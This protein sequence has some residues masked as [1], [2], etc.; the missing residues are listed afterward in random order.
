MML[1]HSNAE[2]AG[3]RRT[4]LC[5]AGA[6]APALS[7][8][9]LGDTNEAVDGVASRDLRVGFNENANARRIGAVHPEEYVPRRSVERIIAEIAALATYTKPR[10]SSG[11]EVA[12][13][14]ASRAKRRG[15][16]NGVSE[17]APETRRSS[18]TKS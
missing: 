14:E 17:I 16:L 15:G 10:R 13:I 6:C 12:T 2:D 5:S 1:L 7:A 18:A 11:P 4:R 9:T 8:I 3:C